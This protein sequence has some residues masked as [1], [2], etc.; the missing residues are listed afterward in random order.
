MTQ[1][2]IVPS[3]TI[4]SVELSQLWQDTANDTFFGTPNDCVSTDPVPR[5]ERLFIPQSVCTLEPQQWTECL[6]DAWDILEFRCLPSKILRKTLKPEGKEFLA[7]ATNKRHDFFP[8]IFARDINAIVATL[9]KLNRGITTDWIERTAETNITFTLDTRLNVY[10]SANPRLTR[11]GTKRSDV[12]LARSIFVELDNTTVAEALALC[13]RA[14]LPDPTMIIVS[15]HGV[16]LYWRLIEPI[17]DLDSWTDLQKSLIV[18]FGETADAAIHDPARVMRVPGFW[19]VNGEQPT[20]CYIHQADPSRRYDLSDFKMLPCM[21]GDVPRK[22]KQPVASTVKANPVTQQQAVP[23]NAD[24]RLKRAEAYMQTWSLVAEGERRTTVFSLVGNLVEKFDLDVSELLEIATKYNDRLDDSLDADEVEEVTTEAHQ[25]VHDKNNPLGIYLLPESVIRLTKADGATRRLS[26]WW[27]ELAE[28]RMDSVKQPGNI[29]F[30]GSTTGAGKSYADIEVMKFVKA[31]ATILPTH[32]A[33]DD[34]VKDFA[35]LGIVAAAHP[36]LERTCQ[37]WGT[38]DDPGEAQKVQNAGLSVPKTLCC[39]CPHAKSCEYQR[40]RQQATDAKHVIATHMR[41]SLSQWQP[42][43]NKEIVFVHEDPY[44]LLRPIIRVAGSPTED[45]HAQAVSLRQVVA[46][47]DQARREAKVRDWDVAD[48]LTHLIDST[49]ELITFLEHPPKSVFSNAMALPMIAPRSCPDT[50]DHLLYRGMTSL[51]LFPPQN[52]VRLAIGHAFGQ[53]EHLVLVKDEPRTEKGQPM[54]LL[55]IVGVRRVEPPTDSVVWLENAHGNP[56]ML[57]RLIGRPVINHTP[58]G[59]LAH[60]VPP[61]HFAQ[62]VTTTTSANNVR[63]L[64]RGVLSRFPQ[65]HKVGIITLQK[66]RPALDGL[67]SFWKKRIRRVEHFRSGKDRASNS[68]LACDLIV[69]LGTP[70]V[71]PSATRSKLIQLGQIIEAAEDGRWRDKAWH[72]ASLDGKDVILRGYGY[73]HP[74]WDEAHQLLV[75]EQLLQ[76]VGRGRSVTDKA[77]QVVVL[78][79]E[80]LNLAISEEDIIPM[81]DSNAT[82]LQAVQDIVLKS[83]NSEVTV[84]VSEVAQQRK[85]SIR[86]I[87]RHFRCLEKAGLIKEAGSKHRWMLTSPFAPCRT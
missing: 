87:R 27:K 34:S 23:L 28:A 18:L 1:G 43:T 38:R 86:Q 37:L 63:A 68:W 83:A 85:L 79:N 6:F 49:N 64:V 56:K 32:A 4:S 10:C 26:D 71:P 33:C 12:T 61:I 19:N 54:P 5:S 45:G 16:H 41:S 29:F 78:S 69:I 66:K 51:K 44:D 24:N 35:K 74:A 36:S 84:S 52:S 15:G 25:H 59:Q 80:P 22:Q 77:V 7:T 46:I 40:L 57:E 50:L 65:S 17:Y 21:K 9:D 67:E 39:R 3:G 11:C 75:R 73:A 8:W 30:D 76:A 13:R 47:A 31:S 42:A 70:R 53:F 55:S 72:Q 82:T 2:I 60:Q 48:C 14:G 62:D 81:R 58:K 20:K